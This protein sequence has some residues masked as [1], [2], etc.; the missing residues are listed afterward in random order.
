M[1][2]VA[3]TLSDLALNGLLVC[4]AEDFRR[5]LAAFEQLALDANGPGVFALKDGEGRALYQLRTGRCVILFYP[6]DGE[7]PLYIVDVRRI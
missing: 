7:L 1:P 2:G 4:A 6:R 3:Y 5:V